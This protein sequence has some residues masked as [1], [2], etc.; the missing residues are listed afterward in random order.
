MAIP[1][2]DLVRDLDVLYSI[3]DWEADPAMSRFAPRV[4]RDIGY[5]YTEVFE[6]DFCQRFNGMMLRSSDSVGEVFCAAFPGP[7]VIA[8]LF[9]LAQE[10]ALLFLHHPID[11]EVAGVGFLPIPPD[12][13][14]RLRA[15]G[16]SVYACHAPMDCH[17]EI[18]TN[19]SIV[20]AFG[21]R[22]EQGFAP[23][24]IGLAGRIASVPPASLDELVQ[25]GRDVFGV[26][27]V[28][29]GGARP[30]AITKVAIV[31][32]GG[33]DVELFEAAE[34]LGAQV[35]ITGEWWTRT[36]PP[37]DEERKWAEGN[38]AACK[39]YAAQSQ[40]AFLGFSHAA[41]EF[42]VMEDQMADYFRQKGLEVTCLAQSDWWR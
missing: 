37:G 23:Y 33:D 31:A 14:E 36:T 40:M 30:E 3:G 9:E 25:H 29:T 8:R 12:Q 35:Y 28:E 5:D 15:R 39:A 34:Q 38:R 10:G 16:V 21:A 13:L 18:G 26:E 6:A 20:E 27:R 17:D 7:G 32:G 22:V 1:L 4:Y 24:G 19:A 11:M 41:T 2:K 42:L